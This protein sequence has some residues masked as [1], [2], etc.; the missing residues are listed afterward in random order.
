[1]GYRS[2]LC[3]VEPIFRIMDERSA[4]RFANHISPGWIPTLAPFSLHRKLAFILLSQYN[5]ASPTSTHLYGA[6]EYRR[7][8]EAPHDDMLLVSEVTVQV[9]RGHPTIIWSD[10]APMHAERHKLHNLLRLNLHCSSPGMYSA[11]SF[12]FYPPNAKHQIGCTHFT[13]SRSQLRR[14]RIFHSTYENTR[15]MFQLLAN[16]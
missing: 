14:P 13:R 9:A 5:Y 3:A 12:W 11:G 16:A 1:M 7:G 2:G 15:E 6:H 4:R 10:R 8:L